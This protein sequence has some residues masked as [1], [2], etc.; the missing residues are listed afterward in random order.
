[1]AALGVGWLELKQAVELAL[2]CARVRLDR[3]VGEVRPA[4]TDLAGALQERL[5]CRGEHGIAGIDGVLGIADQ[6]KAELVRVG[7]IAVRG[8]AI[9]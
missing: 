4:T 6:M 8:K 7:V 9:G 3:G 2:E 1:M 5:E